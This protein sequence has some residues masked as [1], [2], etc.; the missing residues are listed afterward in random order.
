MSDPR[1]LDDLIAGLDPARDA[2]C[3]T[4]RP[5]DAAPWAIMADPAPHSE[6]APPPR[7]G[8]R[9]VAVLIGV[10]VVGLTAAGV[11]I[12][13]GPRRG[14]PPPTGS[15]IGNPAIAYGMGLQVPADAPASLTG[16]ATA[17][18]TW[19]P[20][21]D[22]T[23]A[24]QPAGFG[25]VRAGAIDVFQSAYPVDTVDDH[26]IALHGPDGTVA[27]TLTD[28]G[29]AVLQV[30]VRD[31][32]GMVLG[33]VDYAADSGIGTGVN[34][35]VY[36][37]YVSVGSAW[38]GAEPTAPDGGAPTIVMK[39]L[40]SSESGVVLPSPAP[41]P[42]PSLLPPPVESGPD[43]T[44]TP[45]STSSP[46]VLGLVLATS[47][48][49]ATIGVFSSTAGTAICLAQPNGAGGFTYQFGFQS[50]Y[51]DSAMAT[52]SPDAV[53]VLDSS[54][55]GAWVQALPAGTGVLAGGL[56]ADV[57]GLVLNLSDQT[58]VEVRVEAPYWLATYP[59]RTA[60]GRTIEPMSVTA[61]LA[62]G[63]TMTIG[64]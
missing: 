34:V 7:R 14:T 31:A 27:A 64:W 40:W 49:D 55:W 63:T 60:D 47:V 51:F 1:S 22:I 54:Q 30:E 26:T 15:T 18:T 42:S 19:L 39:L 44:A 29:P 59:S 52:A 4:P 41:V 43:G 9:L 5:A 56:G 25:G 57:R 38:S 16:C 28:L 35:V 33:A 10:L 3:L 2:L 21:T 20:P 61:T 58:H 24:P 46:R 32:R 17:W 45:V 50:T 37:S 8:S 6:I 62:D 13:S 11:V 12:A 53:Y 23:L 36:D 48:G